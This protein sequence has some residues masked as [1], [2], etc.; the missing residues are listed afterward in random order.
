MEN[1]SKNKV[2]E[3]ENQAKIKLILD[4]FNN[5]YEVLSDYIKI[6]KDQIKIRRPDMSKDITL[7]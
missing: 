6:V 1:E 4:S 7:D 5:D 3:I 2:L